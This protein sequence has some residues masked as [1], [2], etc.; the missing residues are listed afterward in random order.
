MQIWILISVFEDRCNRVIEQIYYN[1]SNCWDLNVWRS[2]STETSPLNQKRIQYLQ[3]KNEKSTWNR[4]TKKILKNWLNEL[5]LPR[6]S[7]SIRLQTAQSILIYFFPT[8]F[9][10]VYSKFP[11]AFRRSTILIT[12]S[13]DWL[14]WMDV[15]RWVSKVYWMS[16]PSWKTNAHIIYVTCEDKMLQCVSK[17]E[18][19]ITYSHHR[20]S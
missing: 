17:S 2:L 12:Y 16:Y 13:I 9:I 10:S 18:F 5:K 14:L 1:L 7:K 11:R 6:W 3:I 15:T 8:S 19:I 4:V 20:W